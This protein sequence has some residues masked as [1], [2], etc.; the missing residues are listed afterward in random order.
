[1][2]LLH[3]SMFIY[4]RIC[5]YVYILS[6]AVSERQTEGLTRQ[7]VIIINGFRCNISDQSLSS[8]NRLRPGIGVSEY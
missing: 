1:M 5:V 7:D 2:L 8:I 6:S 3:T 4:F